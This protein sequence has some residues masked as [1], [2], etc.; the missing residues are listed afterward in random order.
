MQIVS[1]NPKK[2]RLP[3]SARVI[4]SLSLV[5]AAFLIALT[6]RNSIGYLILSGMILSF[7][8]DM[9]NAE[10][11]PLPVPLIGG[12]LSFGI[13]H[14]FYISAF[15]FVIKNSGALGSAYLWIILA[16][17]WIFT[18]LSWRLFIRN[19]EKM[20]A[21]NTGSLIYALLIG[22]MTTFALAAGLELGRWWWAVLAGAILFYISDAII[23]ITDIGGKAMRRPHLWIWLTYVLGQMGIIYGVWMGFNM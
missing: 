21:L 23:G 7:W 19:P 4:L 14:C 12:M 1:D 10:V 5:L 8:G 11:I 3:L 16:A 17:I 9:F 2:I 13:A 18:A 15:F 22:A 20:R 6:L